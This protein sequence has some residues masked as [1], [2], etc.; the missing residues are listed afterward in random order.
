MPDEPDILA[1]PEAGDEGAGGTPYAPSKDQADSATMLLYNLV[2][3]RSLT[4]ADFVAHGA[5]DPR[6]SGAD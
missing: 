3:R 4:R 5:I 1:T 6:V 2:Y